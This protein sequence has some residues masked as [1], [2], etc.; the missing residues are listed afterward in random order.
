MSS[1]SETWS[2]SDADEQDHFCYIKSRRRHPKHRTNRPTSNEEE[3]EHLTDESTENTPPRTP[4][5]PSGLTEEDLDL[6]LEEDNLSLLPELAAR[7]ADDRR[8]ALAGDNPSPEPGSLPAPQPIP[9]SGSTTLSSSGSNNPNMVLV[10]DEPFYVHWVLS[11][12]GT[13]GFVFGNFDLL[14]IFAG[15]VRPQDHD[16]PTGTQKK[17]T[18]YSLAVGRERSSQQGG[19][20]PTDL[21]A[22]MEERLDATIWAIPWK[23]GLT[24]QYH[25]ITIDEDKK[26]QGFVTIISPLK[27]GKQ[28]FH[29]VQNG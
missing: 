7:M 21:G 1:A 23:S 22:T 25:D 18:K 12:S 14:E 5:G 6:L 26:R 8:R 9:A 17:L 20:D 16:E 29:G 19:T 13:A 4:P 27:A 11:L 28:V 2:L 3:E 24:P 15:V 10:R